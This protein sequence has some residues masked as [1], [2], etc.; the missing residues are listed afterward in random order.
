MAIKKTQ[1]DFINEC[2][3]VHGNK[4]DYS[5]VVYIGNKVKVCVICSVHGEWLVAPDHHLNSKSGCPKCG[6]ELATKKTSLNKDDFLK[7]AIDI[8][9]DKYDYSLVNYS[10]V[11]QKVKIICKEHGVFEQSV[12]SHINAK[13]GCKKCA[14]LFKLTQEDFIRKASIKH[15]FRYDYSLCK[16]KN[17]NLDKIDIICKKHGVFSQRASNHLFSDGCPKCKYSKGE[18]AISVYLIS[19]NIPFEYQKRFSDCKYINPLPF[20]FFIKLYNIA[21]EF[22][23]EQHYKVSRWSKDKLKM[24]EK[25]ENL[26]KT[27]LIKTKY[28]IDNNIKLIRIPYFN[29]KSIDEILNKEIYEKYIIG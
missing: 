20:D 21:I 11:L 2:N 19:N 12:N 17:Y 10:Q 13:S 5:K 22:D 28:C 23:G 6:R 18:N 8:H 4:Y 16:Y 14:G 25:L 3:I 9:G 7:R 26:K 24:Q 29:L 1:Y 15:H 27:D